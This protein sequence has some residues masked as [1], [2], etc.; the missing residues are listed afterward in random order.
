MSKALARDVQGDSIT[1]EERPPGH[2]DREENK[3]EN[4]E[5][6]VLSPLPILLPMLYWNS[7]FR[8]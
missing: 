3:G 2:M 1:L 8:H 7:R 5:W 6:N 4:R